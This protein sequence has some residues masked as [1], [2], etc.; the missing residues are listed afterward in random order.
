MRSFIPRRRTQRSGSTDRILDTRE[1]RRSLPRTT[2]L[3][4]VRTLSNESSPVMASLFYPPSLVH[5]RYP[6]PLEP[7]PAHLAH[8]ASIRGLNRGM[9]ERRGRRA[10]RGA[11]TD[12]YGRRGGRQDSDD[13]DGDDKE[14]LPAYES[15]AIGGPP[16]YADG[17]L[18]VVGGVPM[19][20][21]TLPM[22]TLASN[23]DVTELGRERMIEQALQR[24]ADEQ[25]TRE[26][27]SSSSSG[28][29][30]LLENARSANVP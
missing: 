4:R 1:R 8:S 11:D 16:R 22:P 13:L 23:R 21:L 12:L 30:C 14:E 3:P 18:H 27:P 29:H 25:T 9:T 10:V 26:P 17:D 6:E 7:A 2:G 15:V 19:H 24:E 5:G 20:I 28:R